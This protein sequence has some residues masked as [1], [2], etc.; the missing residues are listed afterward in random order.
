M[1]PEYNDTLDRNKA[2]LQLRENVSKYVRAV[3]NELASAQGG[4]NGQFN[5]LAGDPASY[6]HFLTASLSALLPPE[7]TDKEK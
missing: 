3:S 2:Y 6:K 1:P 4:V 5:H 7:L